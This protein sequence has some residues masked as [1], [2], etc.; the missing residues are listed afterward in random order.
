MINEERLKPL[1]LAQRLFN[2]ASNLNP[3]NSSIERQRIHRYTLLDFRPSNA[4]LIPRSGL[5]DAPA[6][7]LQRPQGGTSCT[8]QR[9]KILQQHSLININN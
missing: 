5:A 9:P 8:S 4:F 7:I 3:R 2:A 1:L 6:D